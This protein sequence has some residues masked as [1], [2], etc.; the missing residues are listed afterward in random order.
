MRFP[1]AYAAYRNDASENHCIGHSHFLL[2]I[3]T[4]VFVWKAIK[5]SALSL[6]IIYVRYEGFSLIAS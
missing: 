3:S 4:L 1:L 5:S 2:L 6:H